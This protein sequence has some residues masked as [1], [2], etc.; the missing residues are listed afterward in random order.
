MSPGGGSVLQHRLCGLSFRAACAVVLSESR[1]RK[2]I[3]IKIPNVFLMMVLT[4][5]SAIDF[6]FRPSEAKSE[7][8]D[9]VYVCRCRHGGPPW[10]TSLKWGCGRSAQ[11]G[12]LRCRHMI[13][14]WGVA[15]PFRCPS[16]LV[17]FGIHS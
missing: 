7:R 12:V 5:P 17:F 1:T 4:D 16:V 2:G 15:R 6:I 14:W 10:G 9:G 11:R 3:L 13:T 8:P